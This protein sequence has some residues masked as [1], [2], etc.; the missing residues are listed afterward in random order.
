VIA[1]LGGEG[2]L[3][4][5]EIVTLEWADIDLERRQI[6]VRH[7]DWRGQL[8]SPRSGKPGSWR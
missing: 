2:G 8:T 5:G 1:L 4:V 3:R 7:S 6:S